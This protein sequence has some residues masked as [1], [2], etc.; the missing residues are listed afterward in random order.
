MFTRS[1]YAIAGI[2]ALALLL[3]ATPAQAGQVNGSWAEHRF[4]ITALPNA[5]SAR[6]NGSWLQH[7]VTQPHLYTVMYPSTERS[8]GSAL[9][10]ATPSLIVAS[11]TALA[12]LVLFAGLRSSIVDRLR[13]REAR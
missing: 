11:L 9:D 4:L 2:T 1:P 12:V 8:A 6:V 7:G 13:T 10:R 3:P 5:S